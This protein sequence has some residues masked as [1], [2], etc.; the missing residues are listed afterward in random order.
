MGWCRQ[1]GPEAAVG[2]AIALIQDGDTITVAPA[3]RLLHAHVDPR[4]AGSAAH[5]LVRPRAPLRTGVLGKYA[6]QGEQQQ[7]SGAVTD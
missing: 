5:A 3:L 7:P 4:R 6:R 1:R 2:G